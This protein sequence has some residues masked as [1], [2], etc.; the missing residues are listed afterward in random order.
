MHMQNPKKVD[1]L[2]DIFITY[3][4]SPYT[5]IVTRIIEMIDDHLRSIITVA[6][7]NPFI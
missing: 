6:Q 5:V 2:H 4:T 7:Q 3:T 1:E